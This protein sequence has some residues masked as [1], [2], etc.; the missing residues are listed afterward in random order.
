MKGNDPD[1]LLSDLLPVRNHGR[2][3]DRFRLPVIGQ[4]EVDRQSP[5]TA[6]LQHLPVKRLELV[7][8]IHHQNNTPETPA[9]LQIIRQ[10]LLPPLFDR[11]RHLGVAI[12]RKVD[13][14]PLFIQ[15]EEIDQLGPPRRPA[16][17]REALL[18]AQQVDGAGLS[19]VGPACEGN[20]CA[21]VGGRLRDVGGAGEKLGLV[22]EG[23][24]IG[25]S[26]SVV[27]VRG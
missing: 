12:T 18:L 15:C 2:L 21:F 4:Q 22:V 6:P 7:A 3:G 13:D 23:V 26:M 16:G 19:G 8:D 14:P 1:N 27:E 17:A 5:V 9:S 20:L 25:R 11:L 10:A 24:H